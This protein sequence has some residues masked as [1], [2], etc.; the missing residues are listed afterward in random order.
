MHRPVIDLTRRQ[1]LHERKDLL[2][3]GTWYGETADEATPCL[4]ILPR[5]RK[6]GVLPA[7]ITLDA[8]HRWGDD[9]GFGAAASMYMLDGLGMDKTWSNA[10]MFVELVHDH[11]DE[12]IKMP[13]CPSNETLVVADAFATDQ[14]GKVTQAEIVHRL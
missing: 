7:V 14:D 10:Q 12:L 13:P 5:H 8:A 4:V 2:I 3:Y 9:A 6:N 11:L 1:F